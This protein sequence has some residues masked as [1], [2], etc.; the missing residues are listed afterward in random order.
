MDSIEAVRLLRERLSDEPVVASLG[1]PA[2]LLYSAGDRPLNFY[3]WAAMGMAS[4]VGLGLAI[5]QP[6]RR[7][8]VLDGDGAALMNLGGM[9]T[10]GWRAPP[11]LV[12][13]VLENG[14]FLETGG[15]PIATSE[16]ADLVAIARGAGLLNV[17][18]ADN[19]A[20]LG[21]LLDH[22]LAEPGPSLVVAR[23]G[24]DASRDLPPLDPVRLKHRFMEELSRTGHGH[25]SSP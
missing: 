3:M 23:V 22:A 4:S 10:V 7:V 16:R 8:V 14:V 12:W 18:S 9:V 5:A 2:F 11:N 20:D 24:P 17:A 15:Q 21:A 19:P 13:M 1:T 25:E 6:S